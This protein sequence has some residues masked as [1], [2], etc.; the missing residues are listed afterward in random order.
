[1]FSRK[2]L[3]I[4]FCSCIHLVNSW[5]FFTG[6]GSSADRTSPNLEDRSCRHGCIG[7]LT[8]R[9]NVGETGVGSL[10]ASWTPDVESEH[11][12]R[13]SSRLGNDEPGSSS[14]INSSF[15]SSS[16]SH[17]GQGLAMMGEVGCDRG[18]G[19]VDAAGV[20][21]CDVEAAAGGGDREK[22][23]RDI[24]A[25]AACGRCACAEADTGASCC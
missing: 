23:G 4:E 8:D 18:S 10:T 5:I 22:G 1:M 6:G 16:S 9:G 20:G 11:S 25:C 17:A 21:S 7:R 19:D 3:H 15:T 14:S 13:N 24:C 12:V 2:E